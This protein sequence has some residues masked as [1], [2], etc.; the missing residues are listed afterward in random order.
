MTGA[1]TLT[2]AELRRFTKKVAIDPNGCW[3]WTGA[4]NSNGYGSVCLRTKGWLPHRLMF[5]LVNGHLD[6]ELQV[7][8]TCHEWDGECPGGKLCDHRLF[9]NPAHLEQVTQQENNR[10]R[11]SVDRFCLGNPATHWR[12]A[13]A[14]KRRA[15][16]AA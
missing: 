10:R 8:H 3:R 12:V 13:L 11:L 1:L 4:Q 14:Q 9:V 6:P 5:L 15:E 16:R 7:D 2:A